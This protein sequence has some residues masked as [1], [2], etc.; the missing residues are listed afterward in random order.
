MT[1]TNLEIA[2]LFTKLTSLFQQKVSFPARTAF[3]LIRNLHTLQPIVA[4]I[5]EVQLKIATSYGEPIAGQPG[6]YK[7]RPGE[8]HHLA[9]EIQSLNNEAVE[10]SLIKIPLSDIES[11]NLT[12]EDMEAL[13]PLL[14]S[15]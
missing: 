6:M 9:E 10:V 3:I 1:L 8:E 14:E 4:D 15:E 7:A 5:N 12:L 2:T 13:Y 11:I